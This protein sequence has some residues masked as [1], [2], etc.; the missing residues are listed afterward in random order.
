MHTRALRLFLEPW[1][2][3][4]ILAH[5]IDTEM[6]H[7][8]PPFQEYLLASYGKYDRQAVSNGQPH[9]GL[10]RLPRPACLTVTP[11]RGSLHLVM[12][13]LRS[14]ACSRARFR[15]A[16]VLP[17][18]IIIQLFPQASISNKHLYPQTPSHSALE[19]PTGNNLQLSWMSKL[20]TPKRQA[21]KQTICEQCSGGNTWY[22]RDRSN[23]ITVMSPRCVMCT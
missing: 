2:I 15:L 4:Q 11:S 23:V 16:K 8:D 10:P 20:R 3:L 12:D 18:M 9:R 5:G 7:S 1:L 22:I 13:T 17:G 6:H 21:V 14:R 19:N